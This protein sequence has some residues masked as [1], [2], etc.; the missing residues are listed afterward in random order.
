MKNLSII[1]V[2]TIFLFIS[3]G[4]GPEATQTVKGADYSLQI[5]GS[6]SST[7]Q[8]NDEAALQYQNIIK[9]LYVIVIDETKA[10]VQTALDENGL[11]Y[12]YT[13]D[14][15]GYYDLVGNNILSTLSRE[16]LPKPVDTTINGLKAK[17]LDIEGT[18]EGQDIYWKFAFI[19]GKKKYYQIMTWTLASRKDTHEAVMRA[20]VN[21]FKET[22]KS[23]D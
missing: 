12:D 20:M 6:M 5:P 22:S 10:E 3:C 23:K 7:T 16:T 2:L 14:L 1:Y 4:G 8:L 15:Q 13:N 21:S 17:V 18:V 11:Q 9:E 19:E